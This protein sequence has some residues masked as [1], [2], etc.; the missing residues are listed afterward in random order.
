MIRKGWAMN[1]LGYPLIG[2]GRLKNFK[3]D[4]LFEIDGAR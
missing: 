2:I 3:G 4:P 1:F